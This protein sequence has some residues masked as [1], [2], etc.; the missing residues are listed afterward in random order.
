[1]KII[2][3]TRPLS[4]NIL[5]YPGD[6]APVFRQTDHGYYL[7]TDLH[8]STHTGTHIDAPVHYLKTGDT[9]DT[10]PLSHIMGTCRVL[11]LTCAGTSI[12]VNHLKGRLDG[13]DRLL[14]KTS[15]SGTDRFEENYPCLTADAARLITAGAMKCVGID[16]PSIESYHCDGTVHRELLSHGCIIIEL[17][18]LSAAEEGDYTMVAL[19]LRFTG[20]DGSPAR[21][22]L[23]ENNG[24]E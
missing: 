23:I 22:V 24:C 13:I 21:V 8:L 6:I 1:M 17:L 11:D 2:D 5:I 7:I 12:T 9:I 14:L 3:I 18:D 20:L 19:P 15:F 10:I 16:S 4:E